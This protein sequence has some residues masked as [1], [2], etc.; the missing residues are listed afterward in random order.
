MQGRNDDLRKSDRLGSYEERRERVSRFNLTSDIFFCK[1][2]E[3]QAACEELVWILTKEKMKVKEVKTQYSIRNIENHS[4]VLDVLAESEDGRMVN[5]EIHLQEDED[6]VRRVRYYLGSIDVSFLEKGNPFEALPEIYLIYITEVDFI[7]K[8]QGIYRVERMLKDC[9]AALDNGVHEMYVNL[10]SEAAEQD[11]KELLRYLKATRREHETGAFPRLAS[12]VR[13]LKEKREGVEIM[14]DVFGDILELERKE[15][16]E[17]GLA[18]G[19]A[20][21][22]EVGR[23]EGKAEGK[24]EVISIIRK[25][26]QKHMVP[27]EIAELLELEPEYVTRVVT[28]LEN[29]PGA[30][31]LQIAAELLRIILHDEEKNTVA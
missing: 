3:D 5:V 16:R 29:M 11:Q 15:A 25:K 27:V 9:G 17:E 7:G 4:V 19:K 22:K 1:V 18:E 21:G 24:A 26:H 30:D 23:A 13:M 14:C 31:D 6:H 28:L 12:R 20:E 10:Q 8:N 2:M